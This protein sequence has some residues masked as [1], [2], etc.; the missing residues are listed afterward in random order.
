MSWEP[1]ADPAQ[2]PFLNVLNHFAQVGVRVPEAEAFSPEL[3][4][5]LLEDLGDLPSSA[6][7]GKTKI[8]IW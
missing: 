5:V 4:V 7:F 2:Y 6:N 3:G 1:F 8:K